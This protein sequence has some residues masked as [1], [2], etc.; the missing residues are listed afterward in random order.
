MTTKKQKHR[1]LETLAGH[2]LLTV[3]EVVVLLD[4][5]VNESHIGEGKIKQPNSNT[6][7][8]W[9]MKFVQDNIKL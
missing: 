9:G 8:N 3:P 7:T 1:A 2:R 5:A 6:C 4:K